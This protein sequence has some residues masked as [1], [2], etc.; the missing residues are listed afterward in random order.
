MKDI[1]DLQQEACGITG[2]PRP[3]EFT[4]DVVALVEYRDGSIIDAV[5]K[6]KE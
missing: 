3:V 5:R 1:R 4:D 2:E 6:V